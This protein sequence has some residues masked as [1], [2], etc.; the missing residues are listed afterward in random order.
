M[1]TSEVLARYEQLA[2]T[3]AHLVA[4][5][6]D[7]Q[8]EHLPALD[9]RCTELY[10]QLRRAPPE[11]LTPDEMARVVVLASRIRGDQDAL[12]QLLRPQ[13]MALLGG[14]RR[15]EEWAFPPI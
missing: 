9:A 11:D 6:R 1:G 4:L 13:F 7:R 12:V 14:L 5:A 8:W 10:E 2:G 15:Q 3:L